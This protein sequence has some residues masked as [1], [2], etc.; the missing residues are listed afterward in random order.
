MYKKE[1]EKEKDE[2]PLKSVK[3]S[4]LQCILSAME[5]LSDELSEIDHGWE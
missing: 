4:H 5:T 3:T 1:E 2:E